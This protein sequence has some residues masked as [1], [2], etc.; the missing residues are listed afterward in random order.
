MKSL[1]ALE[2]RDMMTL[3]DLRAEQLRQSLP[4]ARGQDTGAD[5]VVAWV[6]VSV[7]AR[8]GP[9]P[10]APLL[11][12]DPVMPEKPGDP[13]ALIAWHLQADCF[14]F[15]PRGTPRNRG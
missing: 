4:P 7:R 5:G 12:T 10:L 9:P 3:A 13:A 11:L 6:F 8:R 2:R 15:A 14:H 1:G